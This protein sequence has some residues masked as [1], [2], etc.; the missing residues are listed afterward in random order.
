VVSF[1]G[2]SRSIRRGGLRRRERRI[3]RARKKNLGTFSIK[4]MNVPNVGKNHL[5]STYYFTL[6]STCTCFLG[7]IIHIKIFVSEFHFSDIEKFTGEPKAKN[8]TFL[9]NLLRE[10]NSFPI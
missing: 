1:K 5:V 7:Q 4:L 3:S 9:Q 10:K 8:L 6:L 2:G